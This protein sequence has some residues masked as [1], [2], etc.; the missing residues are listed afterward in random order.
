MQYHHRTVTLTLTLSPALTLAL[1]LTLRPILPPSPTQV[2]RTLQYHHRNDPDAQDKAMAEA[3]RRAGEAQQ[4]EALVPGLPGVGDMGDM[5]GALE[6][7]QVQDSQ[8]IK[9]EPAKARRQPSAITPTLVPALAPTLVP[10][11]APTLVPALTPTLVPALTPTLVPALAL[12]LTLALAL[13]LT[14]TQAGDPKTQYLEWMDNLM[15]AA[16]Q[17]ERDEWHNRLYYGDQVN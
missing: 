7:V 14:L 3:R 13:A 9:A 17:G 10:A 16:D 6:A 5:L 1:T 12:T 15:A 4:P 11:L 2:L 8:P